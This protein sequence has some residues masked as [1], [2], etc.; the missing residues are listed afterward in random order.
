MSAQSRPYLT[1]EQYLEIERAAEFRSEYY[2]GRM[3]A[4]PGGTIPHAIVTGNLNAELRGALKKGPCLVFA[5][6][7]RVCV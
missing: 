4:M 5:A 7:L 2:K 3:Y 1:P 6:D